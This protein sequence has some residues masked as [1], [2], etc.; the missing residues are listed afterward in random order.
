MINQIGTKLECHVFEATLYSRPASIRGL[1]VLEIICYQFSLVLEFRLFAIFTKYILTLFPDAQT[2][3]DLYVNYDCDMHSANIFK[4]L[5]NDLSKIA[6]GRHAIELG[7]TPLQEKKIRM[8]G[9]ECLVSISKCM[10]EWSKELYVNPVSQVNAS[11]MSNLT[12]VMEH[13]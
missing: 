4:R 13:S 9:V 10:V 6:Q 3:V 7:A 2:V 12:S 1:L 11:G 8:K 5:V